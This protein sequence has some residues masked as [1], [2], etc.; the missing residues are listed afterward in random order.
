MIEAYPVVWLLKI[1]AVDS[2]VRCTGALYDLPGLI[3]RH[4]RPYRPAFSIHGRRTHAARPLLQ[5][6]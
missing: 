6:L 5:H 1:A 2:E 4:V 3:P